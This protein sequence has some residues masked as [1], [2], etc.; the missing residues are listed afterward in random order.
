MRIRGA[1]SPDGKPDSVT[2][3]LL[4]VV[5]P[6]FNLEAE[7]EH[8]ETELSKLDQADAQIIIVD[9]GST[10]G[11]ADVLA[12]VERT[13]DDVLIV[14][15]PKNKG[16]GAARNLGFPHATGRYTLFFDA[17]DFLHVDGIRD[18]IQI[19]ERSGADASINVYDFI[20]DG[21]DIATGM[22]AVDHKIWNLH[23]ARLM[24]RAFHITDCPEFLQ[25]T[26]FPWNKLIRTAHYQSIK[27]AP[28]FGETRVNNDIQGHWN[29]LLNAR[30]LV[31]VDRKIVTHRISGERD[32]LSKKFGGERLEIFAALD[33][34]LDT[35]RDDPKSQSRFSPE[36][37]SFARQ[38]TDWA[39]SRLDDKHR[40]AFQ[41]LLKDLVQ[42]I[43]F[44]ELCS[45]MEAR[46][47]GTYLW[48]LDSMD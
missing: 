32:H 5:V 1:V 22:N 14:S 8:L 25:F 36:Y 38:M 39:A 43:S 21:S 12:C 3:K 19:L 33:L 48:L 15:S 27:L 40:G 42:R 26:N 30:K 46:E 47:R 28:F 7:I 29:I 23:A 41:K 45:L 44:S 20:R 31:V 35:L 37:W 2:S 13:G 4:S 10:D 18:T 34:L 6:A 16:A 24:D 11:T 17:D 9:D